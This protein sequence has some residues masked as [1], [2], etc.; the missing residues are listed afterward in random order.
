MSINYE[1]YSVFIFISSAG[2]D[3]KPQNCGMLYFKTF[4]VIISPADSHA[5]L[6]NLDK[7][8]LVCFCNYGNPFISIVFPLNDCLGSYVDFMRDLKL[9]IGEIQKTD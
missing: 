4:N 8:Y 2:V 6:K 3:S 9:L 5:F 1:G 7:N